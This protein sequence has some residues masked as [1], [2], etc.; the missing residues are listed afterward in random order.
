MAA[1]AVWLNRTFA[2]LK[3]RNFRLLWLGSASEHTGEW[4]ERIAVG[5][6]VLQMT[7]SPF[8]LGLTEFM[9]FIP[10]LVFPFIGGAVADRVDRRKLLIATLLGLSALSAALATLVFTGMVAVWHILAYTFL[11][12]VLIAFNHPARATLLAG[13]VDKAH[14]PNAVSLDSLSVMSSRVIGPPIAGL[15]IAAYGVAGILGVRVVGCLLAVQWLVRL[16]APPTPAHSQGASMWANVIEGLRYVARDR[17]VLGITA[18][19]FVPM[20]FIFVY[21]SQLPVFARDV[22]HAGASGLGWL[23]FAIGMGS[24]I[25]LLYLASLGDYRHKGVLF[26]ASIIAAGLA[27]VLFSASPWLW[28]SLAL[29]LVVGATNSMFTAL[30]STLLLLIVPDHLRG[31]VIALRDL[32]MGSTAFGMLLLGALAEGWGAPLA[33]AALA[34]V[35]TLIAVAAMLTLS[36]VRRLE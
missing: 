21:V 10:L 4:M 31:R 18:M 8:M 20:L 24:L 29:L 33:T 5:W 26:F 6:L 34:G 27:L 2:S 32:S 9:R 3:I 30:R 35:G 14:Y 23:Y 36:R 22:L 1:P 15:Y 16:Q 28:L 19:S 13:V 17:A 12:G 25:S 11:S 7:G